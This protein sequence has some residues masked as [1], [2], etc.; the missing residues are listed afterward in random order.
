MI[1]HSPAENYFRYLVAHPNCFDNK[2]IE[3]IAA[4]LKLD[5]L[6]DWYL[7]WLRDRMAP[8]KPFYPEDE[9]HRA[10][11]RFLLR[12]GLLSAFI[13][14]RA[15]TEALRILSKPRWREIVE[16]MILSGAPN[17]VIAHAVR[18]RQHGVATAE[19]VKTFKHFFWNI[20]LLES[21]EMRVLLDMRHSGML[22]K[23]DDLA[24]A[25]QHVVTRAFRHTDP[26]V[27]AARLP[28]SPLAG[29]VAQM[30]LG[31][32]PRK[33]DMGE[34]AERTM[35][36]ALL[37][38]FSSV[39]TGGPLNVQMGQGYAVIADIMGRL[40]QTLVNPEDKLREDLKRISVATTPNKV[41]TVAQ[42]TGG[43]H[44]VNV[45]P[46]PVEVETTGEDVEDGS[47]VPA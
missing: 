19:G 40:K 31:V 21:M 20:D 30:E 6:G 22:S 24:S 3:D 4:E 45:H 16:S 9:T 38:T 37:R 33:I 27:V 14:D 18:V 28:S 47:N 34:V 8:P 29:L 15:Y 44:T 46:D 11:Y 35:E 41:P 42:L 26:R 7:Q 12:E 10:S 13:P 5:Y 23:G 32:M 39:Q 43:N 25:K 17:D 1:R 36:A 2:Y